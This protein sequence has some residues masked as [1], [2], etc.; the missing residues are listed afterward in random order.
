MI[1]ISASSVTIP[2][3]GT[4]SVDVTVDTRL[5][6]ASLYGGAL[7]AQSADGSV[8][9]RV[10]VG[11]YKEDVRYNLTV[12]GIARDG[13]PARGISWIDIVNADDTTQFT[14]TVGLGQG[15]V[16]VRV[17]PGTYSVM[18]MLFTYDE[19]QVFALEAAIAGDPEIEVNQDTTYVADAQPATEVV[20]NTAQPT[21]PKHWV[22]GTY[23]GAAELGSFESLLLAS[24]PID[25]I[26]AAPTEQV[27]KGDFG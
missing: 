10:P 1:T 27:T 5:G 18:G 6:A 11:F 2:A 23:R 8:V 13:R 12:D 4:A 21:E 9:V 22:I 25:R 26:F 19:P 20:A 17:P 15:P 14:R 16:T 3:G 24:P 7:E